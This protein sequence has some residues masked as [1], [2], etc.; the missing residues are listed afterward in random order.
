MSCFV[1]L[2]LKNAVMSLTLMAMPIGECQREAD[3]INADFQYS[4]AW[5]YCG[6]HIG[7]EVNISEGAGYQRSR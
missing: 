7:A 3:R 4:P 5:A 1:V 2:M 6:V